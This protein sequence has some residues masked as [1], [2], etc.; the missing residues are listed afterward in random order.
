MTVSADFRQAAYAAETGRV[1]KLTT[2]GGTSDA[3]FIKDA[4]PVIEFG[5]VNKTIHQ[6]DEHVAVADL[7]TLTRIYERVL[8][9]WP[10]T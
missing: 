8:A 5:L 7:E 2:G 9:S 10:A 4:C 3:R 6:V 1:P